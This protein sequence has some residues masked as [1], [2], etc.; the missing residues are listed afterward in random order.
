MKIVAS[1]EVVVDMSAFDPSKTFSD[2]GVDS[3]GVMS[4]FLAVEEQLGI[5]FTDDEMGSIRTA[6]DLQSAINCKASPA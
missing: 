3:L 2:N 1:A 5:K 4:I 6:N